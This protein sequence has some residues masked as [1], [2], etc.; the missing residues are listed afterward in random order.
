MALPAVLIAIIDDWFLRPGRRMAAAR[1]TGAADG[2]RRGQAPARAQK[3]VIND[4][5]QHRWQR[6][7]RQNRY[8]L[9]QHA[10]LTCVRPS[11]RRGR[12]P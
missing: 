4:R 8:Q 12:L 7:P 3:P 5:D 10:A 2:A 1:A 9:T 11:A 6:Q